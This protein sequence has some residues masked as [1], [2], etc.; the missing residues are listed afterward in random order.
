M[1]AFRWHRVCDWYYSFRL[2]GAVVDWER[3]QTIFDDMGVKELKVLDIRDR[4]QGDDAGYREFVE[5]CTG[6]FMTG[7]INCGFVDLLA[8]TPLMDRIRQRVHQRGN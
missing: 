8:D 2:T 1:A 7:G 6:I 3:Y 5:E 4:S